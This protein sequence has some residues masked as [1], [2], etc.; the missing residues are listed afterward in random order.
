MRRRLGRDSFRRDP[1]GF[2]YHRSQSFEGDVSVLLLRALV[3]DDH[4]K[5]IPL[6]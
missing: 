4:L 6:V 3:F 2:F 1:K 5:F